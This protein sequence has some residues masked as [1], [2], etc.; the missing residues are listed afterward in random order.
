MK[1][2]LLSVLL[3]LPALAG[4]LDEFSSTPRL[5]KSYKELGFDGET[6]WPS[7]EGVTIKILDHGSFGSFDEVAQKFQNLTGAT[8]QHTEADDT[9][10]ALNTAIREAGEPTFDIIYGIDNTLYQTAVDAGIFRPYEPLLAKN[11]QS[12]FIFFDGPWYATPVDHGY[13]GVNMDVYNEDM[14]EVYIGN[15]NDL[16]ANADLFVTQDPRFSTPGLGFLLVTI[17][18]FPDTAVYDWKDYWTELFENGVKVTSDWTE[19]YETYFTG[20]YGIYGEGHIGGFPIVNSYTGSPA[21]E[22]FYGNDMY[23]DALTSPY[24]TFHQIQ[25]MGILAGSKNRAAAEAW[26]EFTLTESFQDLAA[27]HNAVYPVIGDIDVNKV[28]NRIDPKPGTF[29]TADIDYRI[30]GKNLETWLDEWTELC[31]DYD[32][33]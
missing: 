30:I 27:S 4:C 14:A 24:S 21:Y 5:E 15:L 16:R 20:G 12:E 31:E 29:A 8:V 19:A 6:E 13:I 3:M 28:Y 17:Y 2:A 22:A 33:A 32:C 26:V 25:T 9:G 18:N 11:I 10:D 1:F 7:L 23:G